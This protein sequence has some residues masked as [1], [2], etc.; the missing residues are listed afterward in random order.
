MLTAIR[1]ARRADQDLALQVNRLFGSQELKGPELKTGKVCGTVDG[2]SVGA[3]HSAPGWEIDRVKKNN[4]PA[5]TLFTMITSMFLTQ[6]RSNRVQLSREATVAQYARLTHCGP[7][8][9]LAS[10]NR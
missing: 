3:V 5:P 1:A 4:F 7:G 6:G 8:S 10:G 9:T 2:G